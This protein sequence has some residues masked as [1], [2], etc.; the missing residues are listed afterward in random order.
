M[1]CQVS[2][3]AKLKKNYI[4]IYFSRFAVS[5]KEPV[6]GCV[7]NLDRRRL[8]FARLGRASSGRVDAVDLLHAALGVGLKSVRGW[9]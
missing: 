1:P 7:I 5:S 4:K 8:P 3:F 9:G 2:D 6:F